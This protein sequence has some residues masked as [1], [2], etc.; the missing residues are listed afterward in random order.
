VSNIWRIVGLLVFVLS[1]VNSLVTAQT[2]T[3]A[4]PAQPPVAVYYLLDNSASMYD[5]YPAPKS[6]PEAY[7]YRRPEFQQFLQDLVNQTAK[8]ADKVS[9]ITFN[10]VTN[11]VLPLTAATAIPWDKLFA[12]SGKLD[13]VGATS[14]EDVKLTRMPEALRELLQK[15]QGTAVIWLMTDNIVDQGGS[16]EAADTREFYQLLAGDP[17]IQII[18]AYPILRPPI[19]NQSMLM[20]YG[21]VIGG[22]QP[23][24]LAELQQWDQNYLTAPTTVKFIGGETMQLKPLDRNTIQLSLKEKLQLAAIDE[25]APLQGKVQLVLSSRFRQQIITGATVNLQAEALTPNRSSI[26]TIEGK[27]FK[28]S[29][30]PPYAL[31]HQVQPLDAVTFDIT[32]TTPRVEVSPRRNGFKTLWADIFDETFTMQGRLRANVRDV[33]LQLKAPPSMQRVFGANQIPRVFRPQK[34][35]MAEL[36]IEFTAVVRNDGGRLLLFILLSTLLLVALIAF[37]IWFFLPQQYYLSFDDSFEY[38]RRYSLR[39]KGEVRVKSE[40]GEFLGRLCR[41]WGTDWKFM[42]NRNEFK[43][44]ADAYSNVALARSEASDED[45]AY[46]LFIRTQRPTSRATTDPD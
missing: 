7:Y 1:I 37:L 8:P 9:L 40:S 32:F 41:G 24:S 26:S 25:S 28:F 15:I 4:S 34:V 43:R 23:F 36:P 13:V 18:Y 12:P 20:I 46:R 30:A 6:G 17:R 27:D 31:P 10:R 44:V 11:T 2:P 45:V 42:P 29:P 38:Y 33:K 19:N 14:P 39:R 35:D 21:L 5:G 3:A 22:P 16:Q